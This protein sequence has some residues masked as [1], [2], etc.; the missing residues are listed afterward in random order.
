MSYYCFTTIIL[1]AALKYMVYE[2]W[3]KGTPLFGHPCFGLEQQLSNCSA[4][5]KNNL[6]LMAVHYWKWC[7]SILIMKKSS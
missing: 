3:K 1:H 2:L 6:D 5:S 7:S 4:I